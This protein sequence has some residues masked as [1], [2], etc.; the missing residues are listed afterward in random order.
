MMDLSRPAFNVR[1]F[2][3]SALSRNRTDKRAF[4]NNVLMVLPL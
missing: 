1:Y 2:E 3:K 4:L